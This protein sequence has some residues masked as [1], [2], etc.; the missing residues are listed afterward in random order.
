MKQ[1]PWA[2][3]VVEEMV[4]VVVVVSS[5]LGRTPSK[6]HQRDVHESE[7]HPGPSRSQAIIPC[8]PAHGPTAR[9]VLLVAAA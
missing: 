7:W 6:T 5:S 8:V 2:G 1:S 9:L 4:V 3:D